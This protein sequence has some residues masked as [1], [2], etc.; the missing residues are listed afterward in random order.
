MQ[1]LGDPSFDRINE[2]AQRNSIVQSKGIAERMQGTGIDMRQGS[3]Q[4]TG[5]LVEAT[6]IAIEQH[7]R[8]GNTSLSALGRFQQRGLIDAGIA[9]DPETLCPQWLKTI[10]GVLG[11]A[12]LVPPAN[13]WMQKGG[14]IGHHT[15][16]LGH[17]L[18]ELQSMQR[19]FPGA[20][21]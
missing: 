13:D 5:A 9:V 15:E 2:R 14:R 7:Q 18:S 19:T 16:H 20:A 11:E 17:L 6:C 10:A 21:W 1:P 3:E 12:T 8:A 4:R